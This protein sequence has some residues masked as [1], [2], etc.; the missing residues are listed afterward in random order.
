MQPKPTGSANNSGAAN[1]NPNDGEQDTE[2]ANKP[3]PK[4]ND[5]DDIP[6]PFLPDASLL[7]PE[8]EPEEDEYNPIPVTIDPVAEKKNFDQTEKKKEQE[9]QDEKE[10]RLRR[11]EYLDIAQKSE[12]YSFGWFKALLELEDSFTTEDRVK[13]NPIRVVFNKARIEDDGTLLLYDTPYIPPSIEDVGELRITFY[14]GSDDENIKAVQAE[15]VSPQK[16]RVK[17]KLVKTDAL[18]GFDLSV[19]TKAVVEVSNADFIL[20]KLKAAFKQL[21]YN[22]DDNLHR[23]LPQSLNF[24]FGPPGTGKTTYLAWLIGGLNPHL[25]TLAGEPVLPL[26]D[27]K[28][29]VLVLT[30]TNKASDVLTEKIIENYL[31]SRQ[32]PEWLM[33]FGETKSD[34]IMDSNFFIKNKKVDAAIYNKCTL[35]TTIARFPYDK[36]TVDRTNK[37]ADKWPVKSFK[38][39]YI[40]FDEAS[41]IS[42]ANIV[43]V[44]YQATKV[45]PDVKFIIGGDPF[46][47]HPIIQFNWEG[48]SYISKKALNSDGTP[49]LNDEGKHIEYTQDAGN[50]YS[51]V[52]LIDDNSFI[53][54][55]T[56]PHVFPVHNLIKQYRSIEPIGALFSNYRYNGKLQHDR[57]PENIFAD[58]KKDVKKIEVHNLPL[59]PITFIHFPVKKY[60]SLYRPRS[61]KGSPYQ[62]YSAIFIVEA[63]KYIQ[64]NAIIEDNAH[65]KIGVICPFKIQES[66]INKLVEKICNG[67]I[68]DLHQIE[69]IK[70]LARWL[71]DTKEHIIEY[72]AE[73]LEQTL[74]KNGE[75]IKDFVIPYTHQNVNVYT[76][77]KTKYEVRIDENAIDIKLE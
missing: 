75:K 56:T 6:K 74:F 10:L 34:I 66:I 76:P 57:I 59:K 14:S 23:L 70:S 25:L 26:M 54:P 46:Q 44:I 17:A 30:P 52:G 41:M 18:T 13:R 63:L 31:E 8:T 12:M 28:N 55:R 62:I 51:M 39:D 72:R 73:E 47:I 43:Y 38:W 29:K 15:V 36:F 37:E 67:K 35:I 1:E 69:R 5:S 49:K 45:N 7:A 33:R 27:S 65:Y 20:E 24:I 22:D 3:Q 40:I 64:S 60:E 58:K 50:I 48:W 11:A 42:L 32:Y 16:D 21:P 9:Y 71:P 4:K 2:E 53:S 77:S 19:I 61:I 68:E